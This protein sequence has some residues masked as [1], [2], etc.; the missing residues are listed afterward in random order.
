MSLKKVSK[1]Q[2][3]KFEFSDENLNLAKKIVLN[4]PTGKK[5]SAVMALLYLVQKQNNN[6]IPLAAMKYIAKYLEISY[7]NVYEV[8][9]FYSMYNLEPV[10]KYLVQFCTTTPCWL[11]GSDDLLEICK[12]YL[13]IN[14]NET[15]KDGLFTLKEVECL[16][17]CV[18]APMIQIN[19][20]YYED[21]NKDSLL[22]LID[23]LKNG[24]K[25]KIGS[26]IKGRKGGEPFNK[27]EK[28]TNAQ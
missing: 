4:Y 23:S 22:K 7:I 3:D 11:R 15:T 13:G 19:D 10:G 18:N 5:K 21:L 26:Q 25:V 27:L 20:D 12:K 6:W 9:T 1:E 16:G 2:P 17:A 24:I 28:K 14:I 8:A